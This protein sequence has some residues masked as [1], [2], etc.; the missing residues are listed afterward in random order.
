MNLD[1]SPKVL[2]V[3]DATWAD[4]NNIGNTFSNLFKDWPKNKIGMIYTR[5]DMYNTSVCDTFFQISESR[6]IK[7]FFSSDIKTGKKIDSI[8]LENSDT[9]KKL[10]EDEEAGKKLYRFFLKHRWNIF[11]T[12]RELLW[13]IGDWKTKELDEFID[14]FNPDIVLS[15]A[16]PGM[17]MNRLQQY[18]I[19]RSKAKSIIYFV[20]DV[21]SNKRFN[22]SPIFWFNRQITRKGIRKTVSMCD[23]VYTIIDKQKKEYDSFFD[24]NSKILNKGGD[25]S[26]SLNFKNDDS[27]PIKLIYTGNITSGRWETLV[28]IGEAL[29][30]INGRY[31]KATLSI[32]TKNQ[33]HGKIDKAF[34]EIKSIEFKGSIKANQVK[35]VQNRGDILVHVE[36]MKLK[37]KM[38]TRLSFSTKLVDYF[39][40]G[41]CILAIGWAESASISY[42]KE[43]NAGYIIDDV[44]KIEKNL[45]ELIIRPE[46]I[47]KLGENAWFCGFKHHQIVDI[48]HNIQND[49]MNLLYPDK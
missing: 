1:N 15:L 23:L 29:D 16:C 14:E 41:K 40:R 17:Y 12:G 25:F 37:E 6:L 4:D 36:S 26:E 35:E 21:Y 11:L 19:K 31:T 10:K 34:Q 3:S 27:K 22:L 38:E 8:D 2:I 20:D 13:K 47:K 24:V 33:L 42:L 46:L 5:S 9:K 30:K 32:Y 28:K 49:L 7:R 39:E 43:N 48:R 44:K 45:N 18:I